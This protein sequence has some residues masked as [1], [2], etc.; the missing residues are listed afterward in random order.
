MKTNELIAKLQDGFDELAPDVYS[1]VEKSIAKTEIIYEKENSKIS[2]IKYIFSG[3]SLAVVCVVFFLIMIN[4]EENV[5]IIIDVN[6]SIKLVINESQEVISINGLNEDG[7]RVVNMLDW[8]KKDSS[9]S[10]IKK[11]IKI[12]AEEAYIKNE[13]DI[14]VTIQTVD[15]EIYGKME[16]AIKYEIYE[17]LKENE[18]EDIEVEFYQKNKSNQTVGDNKQDDTKEPELIETINEESKINLETTTKEF[19]TQDETTLK[20]TN[21][22]DTTM[23]MD[24]ETKEEKTKKEKE[25]KEEKTKKEKESKE[26]KN[27][28]EKESKEKNVK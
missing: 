12:M 5:S 21:I 27:K 14:Q 1:E 28:K 13:S 23:E 18:I 20:Q 19:E 4:S 16:E 26:E 7:E 25:S 22:E 15:Y 8:E 9:E 2:M 3:V 6:P 17:S 11:M 24:K 10:V